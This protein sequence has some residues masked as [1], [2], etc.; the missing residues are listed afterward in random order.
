MISLAD[1][2][3]TGLSHVGRAI[4]EPMVQTTAALVAAPVTVAGLHAVGISTDLNTEQIAL[5][6]VEA[7]LWLTL[8]LVAGFGAL[9]GVVAELLSLQG[10]IELPHRVTRHRGKRTRLAEARHMVDL[11]IV[12]RLLL[13]ATAALAVLSVYAP[14][15][16]TA[17]IVTALVAGSAATGVFRL[18]QSRL[19]GPA[20]PPR[21]ERKLTPVR[22]ADEL[23]AERLPEAG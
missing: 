18:V 21:R 19:L 2:S 11:G 3:S 7:R 20:S 23:P 13:G 1:V 22:R 5:G 4:R 12:S 8:S 9:G 6:L 16:P 10:N 14:T 17:L 15:S